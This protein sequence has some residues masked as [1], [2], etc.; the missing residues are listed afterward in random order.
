[1][2]VKSIIAALDAELD[3]LHQARALLS[4][5]DHSGATA[6]K[7]PAAKPVKVARRVLSAGAR[8]RIAEGQRKR[9]A[10]IRKPEKAVAT[11]APKAANA[12]ANKK[13]SPSVRANKT[14]V[15]AQGTRT[16]PTKKTAPPAKDGDSQRS[17]ANAN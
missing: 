10:A 11:P 12:T 3:L 4:R 9:W 5:S 2:D 6:I 15:R 1:M 16:P 8:K 17:T 14:P 7:S 13:K